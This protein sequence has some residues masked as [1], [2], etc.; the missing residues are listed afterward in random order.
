[1]RRKM[2]SLEVSRVIKV[3]IAK[4]STAGE[5]GVRTIKRPLHCN[6]MKY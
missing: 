4:N 2:A 3:L 5:G 6:D 1:M